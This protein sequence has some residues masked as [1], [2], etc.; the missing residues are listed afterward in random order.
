M[1]VQKKT[2][3]LRLLEADSRQTLEQIAAQISEEPAAV[4]VALEELREQ[5]ILK[6]YTAQ[7]DWDKLGIERVTAVID[8][9]ITPQR[10]TGFDRLAQR[11]ARFP[12]VRSC[13]LM[14]GAY[15][16]S[17]KVEAATL[18]DISRF[19]FEKLATMDG[20]ASTATHFIMKQYKHDGCSFG[21]EEGDERLAV[22]P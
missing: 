19:V 1:D 14:S 2:E 21:D 11:I 20:V 6:Q 17:V 16:L 4:A 13:Y 9:K 18:K 8:V 7:V 12:E 15:D 3:I 22:T 10:D 5:R